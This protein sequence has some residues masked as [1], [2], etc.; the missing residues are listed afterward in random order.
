MI[1]FDNILNSF[2]P[3]PN[4]K[5]KSG[6]P[7]VNDLCVALNIAATVSSFEKSQYLDCDTL[8]IIYNNNDCIP[9]IQ[10]IVNINV[11]LLISISLLNISQNA[12]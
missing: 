12:E 2:D 5:F 6:N 9:T 10:K 3:A 7:S 11:P 1:I 8:Y 4:I